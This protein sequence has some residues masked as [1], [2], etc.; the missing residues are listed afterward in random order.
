VLTIPI[1]LSSDLAKVARSEEKLSL[2]PLIISA[3]VI[4][5]VVRDMY[6]ATTLID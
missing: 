4:G 2:L 5:R 3:Q 1:G 6:Q